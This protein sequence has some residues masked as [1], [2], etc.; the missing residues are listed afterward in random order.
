[1]AGNLFIKKTKIRYDWKLFHLK[2]RNKI[3]FGIFFFEIATDLDCSVSLRI[4]SE[5][6][7]MR[8]RATRNMD[9]FYS[10]TAQDLFH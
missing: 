2:C 1:M 5:Y 4:Q 3:E 7:K 6:W 8:T 9:T 10:G